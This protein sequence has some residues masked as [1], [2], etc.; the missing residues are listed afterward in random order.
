[1]GHETFSADEEE[2]ALRKQ[3]QLGVI[4]LLCLLGHAAPAQ[5]F[6]DVAVERVAAGYTFTEGPVWSKE[7][8][9]LFADVPT[10]RL[11]KFTPGEGVDV[12]TSESNGAIGNALDDRGRLYTCEQRKRRVTRSDKKGH[13]EVIAERYN[14][15]RLNA[16]NDIVVTR[17][18]HIYFTDPAFGSYSEGRELPYAVYHVTPKG[19]MEVIAQPKGRPNGVALAPNG[20][21]LYVVNSDE[22]NVR[23][24]DLD[25]SGSASNERIV[26]SQIDG[27]PDGIKTDE[28]GNLYVACSGIGIYSPE[29]KLLRLIPMHEKPSN[30]AFGDGDLQTLYITARTSVY[31]AR[32]DVKGAPPY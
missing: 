8:F 20:K 30:C 26:I 19:E 27:I 22:K 13:M 1:M 31:R 3:H 23:A 29:G 16:P 9:L 24:Y 10:N 12:V 6:N 4:G 15:K 28:K 14:G 17:N 25:R 2:E 21:I 5:D 7:G 11:L 18:G 32:L